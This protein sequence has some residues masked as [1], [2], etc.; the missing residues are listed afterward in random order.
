MYMVFVYLYLS[1]NIK[2]L[3]ALL[4]ILLNLAYRSIS[5][6]EPL[7]DSADDD[8]TGAEMGKGALSEALG[9]RGS[10]DKLIAK[11]CKLSFTLS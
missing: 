5:S 10:P 8:T 3:Y 4:K 1:N 2:G 11:F 7:C 9:A 6:L